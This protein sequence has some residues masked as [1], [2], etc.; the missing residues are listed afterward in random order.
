M[1]IFHS[2]KL[3]LGA[4]KWYSHIR[5]WTACQKRIYNICL[6]VPGEL[7]ARFSERK[8]SYGFLLRHVPVELD[9]KAALLKGLSLQRGKVRQWPVNRGRM[10]AVKELG[11]RAVSRAHSQLVLILLSWILKY[12]LLDSCC[13]ECLHPPTWLCSSSELLHILAT[14]GV[15]IYTTGNLQ[16]PDLMQ[17]PT[18]CL[19]VESFLVQK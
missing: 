12:Q 8:R 14:K 2:I 1:W 5:G 16:D 4:T 18:S 15:T 7:R 13:F 10:R 9:K 11:G 17:Q 6:S 19:I 3:I